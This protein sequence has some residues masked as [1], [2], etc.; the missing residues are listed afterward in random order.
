MEFTLLRSLFWI[1][2]IASTVMLLLVWRGV[3]RPGVVAA[4]WGVALMLQGI[5]GL[6]SPL[7]TVGLILQVGVAVYLGLKL[8]L[9]L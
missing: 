1:P 3:P 2:P 5:S 9:P 8:T 7:W 6:F 4:C